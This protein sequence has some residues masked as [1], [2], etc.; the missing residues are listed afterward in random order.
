MDNLSVN[1][2]TRANSML[3]PYPN[4][5]GMGNN[6]MEIHNIRRIEEIA[7]REEATANLE[8]EVTKNGV[9]KR[10]LHCTAFY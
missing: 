1:D 10:F 2:S 6:R 8:T 3:P 7:N 4:I 9:C 5:P